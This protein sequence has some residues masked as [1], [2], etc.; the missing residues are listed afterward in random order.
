[1]E[2]GT[3]R[4]SQGRRSDAGHDSPSVQT[5]PRIP[6]G[7]GCSMQGSKRK[8]M[9][10]PS[11]VYAL[12]AQGK[13]APDQ[14]GCLDGR[15][16]PS[17]HRRVPC[18]PDG[19]SR[20]GLRKRRECSAKRKKSGSRYCGYSCFKHWIDQVP[21]AQAGN[22]KRGR[23]WAG[24]APAHPPAP[25]GRTAVRGGKPNKARV[26]RAGACRP[27]A[28]M[29][30]PPIHQGEGAGVVEG[31]RWPLLACT[32]TPSMLC[33]SRCRSPGLDSSWPSPR[34]LGPWQYSS[35]AS[36]RPGADI[37]SAVQVSGPT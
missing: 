7:A 3:E 14:Q 18:Q 29:A 20:K 26:V 32:T 5:I 1:M 4:C 11:H 8:S 22:K 24:S 19:G 6:N 28:C 15:Q 36:S 30:E 33:T 23:A 13:G 25:G 9:E 2:A 27:Q 17:R 10:C 34:W 16:W 12:C 31:H 37:A 21:K 35:D